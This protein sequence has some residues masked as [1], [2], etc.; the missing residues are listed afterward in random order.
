LLLLSLNELVLIN[1]VNGKDVNKVQAHF[2]CPPAYQVIRSNAAYPRNTK[3]GCVDGN[4]QSIEDVFRASQ[5]ICGGLF[6]CNEY[7]APLPRVSNFF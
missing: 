5:R 2:R 4:L 1:H 7:V 3:N 6:I